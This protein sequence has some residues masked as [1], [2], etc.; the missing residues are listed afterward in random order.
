[1]KQ[2]LTEKPHSL[3][4]MDGDDPVI[5]SDEELLPPVI[6]Y[7]VFQCILVFLLVLFPAIINVPL[8]LI[9][10]YTALPAQNI[11]SVLLGR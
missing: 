6:P 9:V 11:F 10:G 5:H 2:L 8:R 3:V 4:M 1:M 7:Y